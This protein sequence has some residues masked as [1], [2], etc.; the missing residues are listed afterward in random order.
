M[1]LLVDATLEGT[2]QETRLQP[3]TSGMGSMTIS[4]TSLKLV[5]SARRYVFVQNDHYI[6]YTVSIYMYMIIHILII[7]HYRQIPSSSPTGWVTDSIIKVEMTFISVL[8]KG[9]DGAISILSTY[10]VHVPPLLS[11]KLKQERILKYTAIV[12]CL[13]SKTYP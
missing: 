1:I 12:R 8:Q 9:K 7:Y 4:R 6:M 5:K 13:N 3:D 2:R 10:I 11:L